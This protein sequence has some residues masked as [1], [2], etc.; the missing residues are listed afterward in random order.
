MAWAVQECYR[1]SV[2]TTGEN[3]RAVL[4]DALF[5]LRFPTMPLRDFANQVCMSLLSF[6][7]PKPPIHTRCMM[8]F[9]MATVSTFR[10]ASRR[11]KVTLYAL[12]V[13]EL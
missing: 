7:A 1:Q 13:R 11:C 10:A 6:W 3:R 8:R 4:G 9:S 5:L 12:C 2:D